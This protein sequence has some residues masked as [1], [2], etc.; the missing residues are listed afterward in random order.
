MVGTVFLKRYQAISQLGKGSMGTV[1]LARHVSKPEVV[2]VKVIHK[3]VAAEPS[4]RQFFDREIESMTQLRH[5][6]VVGLLEASA[7]DPA[8]PCLV[9]EFI[10]GVTLE[11]LLARHGVLPVPQ[12]NRLLVPLCRA[13]T[14]GQASGIIH[15]DLKPANLMVTDPDTDHETLKVMDF[16]LAQLNAKPHISLERL[17]GGQAGAYGTPVYIAPEALRGDPIDHRADIYSVGVIL[18]ELLAGLPPFNY[19]DSATVMNAHLKQRPP[20]LSRIRPGL[21]VPREV[22]EVVQRCLEKYPHER[23]QTARSVAELF[24]RAA[25][26]PLTAEQFPET[27]AATPEP[28]TTTEADLTVPAF[29]RHAVVQKLDAFMPEPI[30]VVKLRGFVSDANGDVVESKPGVI[31][32]HLDRRPA[33]Q[34]ESPQRSV[35]S[36][37]G[38][39]LNKPA[40]HPGPPPDPIELLLYMAHD[41]SGR[42]NHLKLTIVFQP[43]NNAR[44]NHPEAWRARCDKLFN[45]LRG[46]LMAK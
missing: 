36:W 42:G 21:I 2:V 1:F 27:G 25:G 34:A 9:M 43:V 19:S 38:G 31:R 24:G 8:G 20:Q 14:A 35:L 41:N 37:I 6:C 16:G 26:I 5:P 44:L 39:R 28:D 7:D 22:E 30:A 17:H 10:P 45:D 32:V 4:F 23:P 11:A 29:G 40:P 18:F 33:Q 46:Y 3:A 13:L 15:R 12:V